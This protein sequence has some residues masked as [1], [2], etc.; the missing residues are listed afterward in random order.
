LNIASSTIQ[1][2]G[3][4]AETCAAGGQISLKTGESPVS[5][6]GTSSDRFVGGIVGTNTGRVSS[7][8]MNGSASVNR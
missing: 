7:C 4:I 3:A 6:T 8:K 2:A 5:V 1:G